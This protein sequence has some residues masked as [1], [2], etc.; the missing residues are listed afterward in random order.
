MGDFGKAG[1]HSAVFGD[2]N[3]AAGKSGSRPAPKGIVMEGKQP[4][5]TPASNKKPK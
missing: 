1:G 5:G 4:A 2:K 3:H